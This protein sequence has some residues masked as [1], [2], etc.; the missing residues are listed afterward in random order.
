M[1]SFG[2]F[3]N[4]F[5]IYELKEM[6]LRAIGKHKWN[7]NIDFGVFFLFVTHKKYKRLGERDD[8]NFVFESVLS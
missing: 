8:S 6:E 2:L 5:W 4:L 1:L 7:E 3:V